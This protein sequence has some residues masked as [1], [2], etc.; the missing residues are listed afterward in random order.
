MNRIKKALMALFG[1][2]RSYVRKVNK[3]PK[4]RSKKGLSSY[5]RNKF[6]RRMSEQWARQRSLGVTSNRLMSI[7]QMDLISGQLTQQQQNGTQ[8]N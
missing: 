5:Y 3:A 1:I 4:R 2:K 6:S 7:K 8:P